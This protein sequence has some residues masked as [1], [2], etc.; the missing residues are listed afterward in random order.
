MATE[1]SEGQG[2]PVKTDI[3][4]VFLR[5]TDL[6][7]NRRPNKDE[8]LQHSELYTA[9]SNTI[10]PTHITG[11]QRVRGMWRVYLDNVQDKVTLMAEGIQLR[12]KLVQVIHSNPSRL[13][14]EITTRVR[15]KNVPLSV[16]D[17]VITRAL[18]LRKIDV[19][20]CSREKLRVNGRLTNCATGDR[21]CIVKSST[22]TE[23]LP[24]FMHFGQF[25]GKC[26]HPGQSKSTPVK[27]S[28]ICT[29]CHEEGHKFSQCMN[30]WVC[31]KCKQAGHKQTEC[32][33]VVTADDQNSESPPLEPVQASPSDSHKS[34]S[35]ADNKTSAPK[36]NTTKIRARSCSTSRSDKLTSNQ[37]ISIERFVSKTSASE[38]PNKN[39]VPNVTN[40]SPPTPVD[41]LH[42]RVNNRAK[43]KKRNT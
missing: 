31:N 39:R 18:T 19:I 9:I 42:D 14:S 37:Q 33:L 13:D 5:E 7:G 34:S 28:S 41:E 24:N 8:W 11:L 1:P 23:P 3:P 27:P 40:R 29:K 32:T 26:L 35:A 10:D 21:L 6:F 17:G 22:L 15:I 16:D 25:V 36:G 38:T 12:G 43:A 4:L 30:E 20:E 2:Q